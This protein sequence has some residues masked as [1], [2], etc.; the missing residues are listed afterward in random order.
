MPVPSLKAIRNRLS[1]KLGSRLAVMRR[2]VASWFGSGLILTKVRGSDLG[3]GTV[4][5]FFAALVAL[6]IG[7]VW[8]WGGQLVAAV[9]VFGL[10]LWSSAGFVE[11]EGDAGWIVIDEAAGTFVALIGLGL[12]PGAVVA[13]VIFR[14]AD[15]FKRVF[16]GVAQAEGLSGAIGITTDDLVAGLYGLVAGH[17]VQAL[18]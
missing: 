14:A 18:F 11:T 12:W 13:W 10:A 2:L 9:I 8:G 1:S 16:P 7:Q 15:I 3:S 5:A 4:G 17:L 6:F